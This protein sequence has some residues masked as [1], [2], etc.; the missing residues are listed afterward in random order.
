MRTTMLRPLHEIAREIIDDW[1]QQGKGVS[2]YAQPYLDALLTL[3]TINDDYGLDSGY[4]IVSYALSNMST[5]KGENARMLK[6]EL[7][8]HLRK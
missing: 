8:L 6:R 7:K 5:Y 4:S 1:R 2:P 3:D